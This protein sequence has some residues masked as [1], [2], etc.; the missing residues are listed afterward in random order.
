MVWTNE[1]TEWQSVN[2]FPE[3]QQ[4][5]ITA[6]PPTK[7]E[8]DHQRFV[9]QIK[10]NIYIPLIGGFFLAFFAWGQGTRQIKPA[11]INYRMEA[12]YWEEHETSLFQMM[13]RPFR[14]LFGS[15]NDGDFYVK[16]D[17]AVFL[18]VL[19]FSMLDLII[20]F[21]LIMYFFKLLNAA[22]AE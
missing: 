4:F 2:K 6:P 18:K 15:Y 16:K 11:E 5:I 17:E 14:M 12:E 22:P 21:L 13:T 19:F 1:H 7:K 8:K 9:D 3:L 10:A 20:L